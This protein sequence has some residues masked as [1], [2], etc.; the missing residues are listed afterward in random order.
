MEEWL[1][2][3]KRLFILLCVLKWNSY[4]LIWRGFDCLMSI[5]LKLLPASHEA[6]EKVH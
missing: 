6:T 1:I 4:Y 2:S 5:Q 3:E